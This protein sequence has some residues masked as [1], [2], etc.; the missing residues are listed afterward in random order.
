[1]EP[2]IG[3]QL[4]SVRN[5]LQSDYVG[6][7]EK[8]AEIGYRDLELITTVTPEGLIFGQNMRASEL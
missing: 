1:M 5:N 2:S 3:L 6:T 8:I 7:L 4:W